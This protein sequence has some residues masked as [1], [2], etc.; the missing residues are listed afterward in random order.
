M[1]SSKILDLIIKPE[2]K[3]R[4]TDWERYAKKD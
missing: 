1:S 4:Y 3:A 2:Y